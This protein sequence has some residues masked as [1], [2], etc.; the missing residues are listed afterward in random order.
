MLLVGFHAHDMCDWMMELFDQT[1]SITS[2][3][4]IL[5]Q[6]HSLNF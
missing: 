3:I 2:T 6:S 4:D 1:I 5:Y